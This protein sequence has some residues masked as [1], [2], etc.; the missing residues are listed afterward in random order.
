MRSLLG[1]PKL[2]IRYDQESS[3]SKVVNDVKVHHGE[4]VQL[5]PEVR[6]KNESKSAGL[7]ERANQS[8]EGQIRVM[9]SALE[10]KLGSPVNPSDDVF[11]WMVMHSGT[12]LNRFDVQAGS[13]KTPWELLLQ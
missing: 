13:G 6:P 2:V 12:L 3:L 11:P 9:L 4:G 10:D 7:V 8:V 1:Y 5:V